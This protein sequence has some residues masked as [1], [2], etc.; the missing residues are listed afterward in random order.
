M[1]PSHKTISSEIS[2]S[3]KLFV[4]APCFPF[5]VLALERGVEWKL[6]DPVGR[7]EMVSAAMSELGH[8]GPEFG[9]YDQGECIGHKIRGGN[10]RSQGSILRELG[11]PKILGP[12]KK[13]RCRKH[14]L[15]DW[16]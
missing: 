7:A 8:L 1:S 6:L 15:K 13:S 9:E 14:K 11:A 5:K 12:G 10:F 2:I 16:L 3:I 4:F